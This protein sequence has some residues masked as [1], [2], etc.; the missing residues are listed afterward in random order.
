LART[1]LPWAASTKKKGKKR[2]KKKEK[3]RKKKKKYYTTYIICENVE[4]IKPMK[5]DRMG[6]ECGFK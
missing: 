6:I 1:P 5:M 2:A 4:N 3:K